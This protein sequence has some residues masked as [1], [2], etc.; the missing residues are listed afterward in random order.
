MHLNRKELLKALLKQ[1]S[2]YQGLR[3]NYGDK[4]LEV[5]Y[6]TRRLKQLEERIQVYKRCKGHK[7]FHYHK[8]MMKMKGII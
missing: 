5:D 3:V 6:L 2:I 1:F 7:T 4:C 8:K